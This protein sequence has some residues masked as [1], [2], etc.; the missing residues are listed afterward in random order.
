MVGL[1]GGASTTTGTG[2]GT[3][4]ILISLTGGAGVGKLSSSTMMSSRPM[5][6]PNRILVVLLCMIYI[7]LGVRLQERQQRRIRMPML[8]QRVAYEPIALASPHSLRA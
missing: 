2:V 8:P 1:H 4:F 5:T 3:L 7:L 6:I